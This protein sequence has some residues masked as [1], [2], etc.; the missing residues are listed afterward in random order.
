MAG[1][2]GSSLLG[3]KKYADA[4]QYLVKG[5]EGMSRWAERL[6]PSHDAFTRKPLTETLQR[7]VQL[8]DALGKPDEAAK[9]RKELETHRKATE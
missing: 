2:L 1:L 4:E 5:C 3:Q 6:G 7:L 9:W 8:Y